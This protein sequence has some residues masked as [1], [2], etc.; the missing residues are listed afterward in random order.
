MGSG[1]L[2]SALTFTSLAPLTLV[3]Q[4]CGH[5]SLFVHHYAKP[6]VRGNSDGL[7]ALASLKVQCFAETQVCDFPHHLHVSV[8]GP[9][10]KGHGLNDV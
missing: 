10:E 1:H 3:E 9:A 8:G 5:L 4:S 6:L 7:S 2:L